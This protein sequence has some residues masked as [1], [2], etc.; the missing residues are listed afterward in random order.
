[1]IA[2]ARDLDFAGSGFFTGLSAV[3]LSALHEAQA[4]NMRTLARQTFCHDGSPFQLFLVRRMLQRSLFA[5]D[6]LGA[7]D[8]FLSRAGILFRVP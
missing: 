1:M 8:P 7:T 5:N 4:W 6:H 3:F 2:L